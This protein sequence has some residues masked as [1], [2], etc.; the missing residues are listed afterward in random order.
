MHF[1]DQAKCRAAEPKLD[2]QCEGAAD[3]VSEGVAGP[4]VEP[5]WRIWTILD[6]TFDSWD[7]PWMILEDLGITPR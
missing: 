2:P 5:Q 1:A 7:R 3:A 4:G 6:E